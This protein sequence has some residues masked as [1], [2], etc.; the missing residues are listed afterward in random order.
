MIREIKLFAGRSNPDL[1]GRLSRELGIE[2]GKISITEFANGE[3]YV[4][5]EETV[6]DADVFV[7]QTMCQPVN[8]NFMELCIMVDALKRASAGRINVIMPYYGYSRQ[9]KKHAPREPISARMVADILQTV[10]AHRVISFDLHS[11]AIQGFFSIVLDHLTA[12]PLLRDYLRAECI[13]DGVVIAADAGGVKRAE[14]LAMDLRLPLGVQYKRRPGHNEAEPS[15]FTGDVAGKTP[16]IIE[17][18]IDTG[19]SLLTAVETLV[20]LGARPDIRVLATHALFS[21]DAPLRL[22]HVAIREIVVTDTLPIPPARRLP[23]MHILSIAPM[24]AAIV[25]NIHAGESISSVMANPKPDFIV[26]TT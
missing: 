2:L 3:I 6:R 4:S 24:L 12:Y 9:E 18:M 25:R 22:Q 14:R 15:T 21:G 17:D 26:E 5:Y 13:Q 23:T 11:P 7:F 19:K 1:A 20:S 16:I 8:T 10:G